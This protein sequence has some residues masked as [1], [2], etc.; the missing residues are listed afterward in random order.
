[1][2]VTRSSFHA[3]VFV[4][5]PHNSLLKSMLLEWTNKAE[6]GQ[7]LSQSDLAEQ[8]SILQLLNQIWC[9]QEEEKRKAKAEEASLYVTR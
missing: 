8:R 6:R 4:S 3:S 9:Q 1:M 7:T 5:L 2:H